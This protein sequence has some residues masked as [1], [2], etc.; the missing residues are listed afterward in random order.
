M[1]VKQTEI[2]EKFSAT[3]PVE[4][5][6]RWVRMVERWEEDPTAPNPYNEPE[7]SKFVY[8]YMFV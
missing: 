1:S 2:F 4:T 3:F 7:Q 6:A 5:V 8:P